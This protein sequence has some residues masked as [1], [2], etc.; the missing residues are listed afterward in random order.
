MSDLTFTV[1]LRSLLGSNLRSAARKLDLSYTTLWSWCAEG[2]HRR[3]P[4]PGALGELMDRLQLSDEE[5]AKFRLLLEQADRGR[6][7]PGAE[8]EEGV[9]GG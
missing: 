7:V 8:A 5:R 1:Y 4:T 2:E 6:S 3:L 9:V